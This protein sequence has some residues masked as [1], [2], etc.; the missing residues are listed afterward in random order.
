MVTLS[1][2][3]SGMWPTCK[4]VY[5]NNLSKLG[6]RGSKKVKNFYYVKDPLV[7][8]LHS[9]KISTPKTIKDHL[10][11]LRRFLFQLTFFVT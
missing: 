8:V 5:Q 11:L 4:F 7:N 10:L 2:N 3:N 1:N 6:K 9:K